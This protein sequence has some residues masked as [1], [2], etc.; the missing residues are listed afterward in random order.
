M[1]FRNFR[2]KFKA[3]TH[4]YC[5]DLDNLMDVLGNQALKTGKVMDPTQIEHLIDSITLSDVQNVA[6]RIVK[7]KGSLVC[8]GNT[9][10]A[11]NL[12]DLV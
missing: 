6:S 3:A 8:I 10:T 2:T 9:D 1:Y 5:E 12:E 7:G 4:L 11:A